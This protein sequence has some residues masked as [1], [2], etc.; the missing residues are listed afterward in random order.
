[1][2][3]KAESESEGIEPCTIT[4][5]NFSMSPLTINQ[6]VWELYYKNYISPLPQKLLHCIIHDWNLESQAEKLK[7]LS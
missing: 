7:E 3:K 1:M 2:D 4:H 5:S 6:A